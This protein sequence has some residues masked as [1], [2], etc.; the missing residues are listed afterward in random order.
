MYQKNTCD[1]KAVKSS[2]IF[3]L[4]SFSIIIFDPFG[5]NLEARILS[6]V[7]PIYWSALALI[8]IFVFCVNY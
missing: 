8:L 3:V 1:V 2:L 4:S 7:L 5:L 6:V